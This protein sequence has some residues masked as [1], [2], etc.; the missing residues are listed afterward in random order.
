M[1]IHLKQP[2]QPVSDF[3][4]SGTVVTVSG[5]AV[6]CA[7][8]QQDVSVTLEIRANA[9]GPGLGGDGAYLAQIEIPARRYLAPQVPMGEGEEPMEQLEAQ[10]LDPSAVAVTLWPAA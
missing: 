4:I 1:Q 5:V 8:Q 6:D 7:V 3:A 9:S 2:G 10:P